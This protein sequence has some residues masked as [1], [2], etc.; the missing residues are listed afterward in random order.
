MNRCRKINEEVELKA[1]GKDI[2][3]IEEFKG[4]YL[5]TYSGDIYSVRRKRIIRPSLDK[6]GYRRVSLSVN[7]KT[8]YR[9]M[10]RLVAISFI[11]NP[12]DKPQVNHKN[13]IKADDCAEN[14]EWCTVGENINHAYESLNRSGSLKG[15]TGRRHH[16]S[17]IVYQYDVRTKKVIDAFFFDKRG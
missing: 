5:I 6:N 9:R 7:G 2:R 13:G 8:Y 1:N 10:C 12:E 14:L 17:F 15:R 4:Y 3:E 11:P 16:C